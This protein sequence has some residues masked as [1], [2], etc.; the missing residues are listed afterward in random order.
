MT[1]LEQACLRNHCVCRMLYQYAIISIT[2]RHVKKRSRH[3]K[4]ICPTR[5]PNH[6]RQLPHQ[7]EQRRIARVLLLARCKWSGFVTMTDVNSGAFPV[8]TQRGANYAL[9]T[10]AQHW[11]WTSHRQFKQLQTGNIFVVGFFFYFFF[12]CS[13]CLRR[14]IDVDIL[15]LPSTNPCC[16]TLNLLLHCYWHCGRR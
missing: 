6:S 7:P 10:L 13:V 5:V 11:P 14:R 15:Y 2:T 12:C 9:R 16:P 1:P 4:I 3:R 8:N